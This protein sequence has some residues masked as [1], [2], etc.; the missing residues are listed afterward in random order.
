M[1]FSNEKIVYKTVLVVL[2]ISILVMTNVTFLSKNIKDY[3]S[4]KAVDSCRIFFRKQS[5]IL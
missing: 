3:F 5:L 4:V 1:R 2:K